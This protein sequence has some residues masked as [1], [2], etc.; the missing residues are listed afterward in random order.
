MD[1]PIL[2]GA[3]LYAVSGVLAAVLFSL[4]T[5]PVAEGQ[6]SNPWHRDLAVFRI[7]LPRRHADLF[8]RL[9]EGE[10]NAGMD[11]LQQ[12]LPELTDLEV[13]LELRR[14]LAAIGDSHTDLEDIS[15]ER[16]YPFY[17]YE[18]TEGLV[19]TGASAAS[20]ASSLSR[21][22]R[23]AGSSNTA[24]TSGWYRE[25]PRNQAAFTASD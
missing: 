14:I 12:R 21:S 23:N 11:A 3:R 4:C 6:S 5:A 16:V 7:M 18:F 24:R 15:P 25:F 19:I 8:H 1:L 10:L 17:L 13:E 22:L 2:H 20:S 9:P